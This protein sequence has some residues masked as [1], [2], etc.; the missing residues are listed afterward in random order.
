MTG[1]QGKL[2]FGVEIIWIKKIMC[3]YVFLLM[4]EIHLLPFEVLFLK[5]A[6]YEPM[7]LFVSY[8]KI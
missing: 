3:I 7:H 1:S 6:G 4:E 8:L 5:L 2:F